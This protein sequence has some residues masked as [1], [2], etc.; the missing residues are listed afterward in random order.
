[1]C[2]PNLCIEMI[3]LVREATELESKEAVFRQDADLRFWRDCPFLIFSTPRSCFQTDTSEQFGLGV[4]CL[5]NR[6]MMFGQVWTYSDVIFI[7]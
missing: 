2:S 1:M 3:D 4:L 5:A 6:S 7:H